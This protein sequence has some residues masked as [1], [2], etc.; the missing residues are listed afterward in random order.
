MS[1]KSKP[2]KAK[3]LEQQGKLL[4]FHELSAILQGVVV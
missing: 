1:K 4:P 2:G 3:M